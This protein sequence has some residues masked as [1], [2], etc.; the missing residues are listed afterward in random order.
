MHF[1][2]QIVAFN[3]HPCNVLMCPH[4]CVTNLP[5][6]RQKQPGTEVGP[7]SMIVGNLV[8][9]K[10]IAQACGRDVSQLEDNDQVKLNP[11]S[12]SQTTEVRL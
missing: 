2:Y 6:P 5:K 11:I 8:A 9:G 10:R 4:T 1:W 12:L 7:A 3:L